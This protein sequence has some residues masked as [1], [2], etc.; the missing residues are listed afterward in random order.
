[1]AQ[2]ELA[3]PKINTNPTQTRPRQRSRRPAGVGRTGNSELGPGRLLGDAHSSARGFGRLVVE[4][5]CG[6]V[7][8][9]PEVAGEPWRAVFTENGRRR[10]RQ[11]SSEAGLAVKLAKV[12]ERLAAGAPNMERPGA[13][14]I[15]HYLDPDRLPADRRWSRKHAHTQARL[16]E[17]F[18][19]PVIDLVV[20]QDITTGH[21]QQIVNAAPTAG[22]GAR[23]AGMIS[24]LVSAGIDASPSLRSPS[25][26]SSSRIVTEHS[27]STPTCTTGGAGMSPAWSVP[28]SRQIAPATRRAAAGPCRRCCP[29]PRSCR[30]P[31]R[32]PSGAGSPR[33]GQRWPRAYRPAGSAQPAGPAPSPAPGP[34]ATRDSDHQ[35]T[36]GSSPDHATIALDRCSSGPGGWS[37]G[38][39][40]I[41]PRPRAASGRHILVLVR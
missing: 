2:P 27:A 5:G 25:A 38:R 28:G 32:A 36:R 12:T 21:T 22:E 33:T 7:V 17:R 6:V 31:G 30:P 23:V 16:C 18:A 34:P 20:C 40:S 13:D 26:E 15:A 14:L 8:Y 24:A 4:V 37:A 3:R 9:P 10:F 1:M 39:M 41:T 35:T 11:A 19:A 29:P